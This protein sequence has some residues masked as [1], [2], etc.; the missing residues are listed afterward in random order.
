MSILVVGATEFGNAP[1][2]DHV[3]AVKELLGLLEAQ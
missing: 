1:L 2:S 3:C